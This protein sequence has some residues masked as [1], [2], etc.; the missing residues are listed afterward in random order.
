M[1]IEI[2]PLEDVHGMIAGDP[3]TPVEPDTTI[4]RSIATLRVVEQNLR[5]HAEGI[6]PATAV[7]V[8][9]WA[10]MVLTVI[11]DLQEVK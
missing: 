4:A 3:P 10:D 9:C 11:D 5:E 6:C 1:T 7:S 2:G 8:H